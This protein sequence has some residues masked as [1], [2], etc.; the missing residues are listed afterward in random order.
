MLIE[1]NEENYEIIKPNDIVEC[2]VN[3]NNFPQKKWRGKVL[4]KNKDYKLG[5]NVEW[6]FPF[7]YGHDCAGLGKQKHCR[8]YG[9]EEGHFIQTLLKNIRLVKPEQLEF[10]F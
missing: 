3:F 9:C 2:V 1:I 8:T 7:S 5:L 6:E 4:S 10:D